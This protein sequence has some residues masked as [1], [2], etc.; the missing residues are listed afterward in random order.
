[1]TQKRSA[2]SEQT[3]KR[4]TKTKTKQNRKTLKKN[5]NFV[6]IWIRCSRP[7]SRQTLNTYF[8]FVAARL[9]DRTRKS[10]KSN[11][12]IV[13]TTFKSHLYRTNPPRWHKEFMLSSYLWLRHAVVCARYLLAVRAFYRREWER[14]DETE[15][16][17][18]YYLLFKSTVRRRNVTARTPFSVGWCL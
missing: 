17:I 13:P 6:E 11:K 8:F 14:E 15:I 3:H 4:R 10:F 9:F 16:A 7:R 5:T 2:K 18:F 1:M 12:I